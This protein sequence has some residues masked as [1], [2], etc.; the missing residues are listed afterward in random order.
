MALSV[1]VLVYNDD[2]ARGVRYGLPHG[3]VLG[4]IPVDKVEKEA[5]L[6][7]ELLTEAATKANSLS[8][9]DFKELGNFSRP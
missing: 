5:H 2:E 9:Q 6:V 7:T 1:A 8:A 3:I 4:S